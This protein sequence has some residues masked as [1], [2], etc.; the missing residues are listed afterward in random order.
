MKGGRLKGGRF[1]F[2][3]GFSHFY[4]VT[5]VLSGPRAGLEVGSRKQTGF[6]LRAEASYRAQV[7]VNT[8]TDLGEIKNA[9]KGRPDFASST[10]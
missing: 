9:H 6:R 8:P 4:K 3:R 2:E 10:C 1:S 5:S 7:R